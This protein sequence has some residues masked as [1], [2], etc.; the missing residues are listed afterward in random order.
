MASV[1]KKERKELINAI[2]QFAE[3]N[4]EEYLHDLENICA[5]IG[6]TLGYSDVAIA[7]IIDILHLSGS[8]DIHKEPRDQ[9]QIVDY[10]NNAHHKY[11]TLTTKGAKLLYE[12][13]GIDLWL[14]EKQNFRQ[15]K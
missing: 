13:S 14:N 1:S 15:Q 8:I 2:L 11:P 10:I 7:K 5:I 9:E 3:K 4:T 6:V 12:S